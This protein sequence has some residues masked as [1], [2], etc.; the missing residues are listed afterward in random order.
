GL[1]IERPPRKRT[2]GG[3]GRGLA[4]AGDGRAQLG[5]DAGGKPHQFVAIKPSGERVGQRTIDPIK[6]AKVAAL[7]K[8]E[9]SI[10]KA[11]LLAQIERQAPAAAVLVHELR[12]R[13]A[14][15]GQ[16]PATD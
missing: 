13:L 7:G 2:Q 14:A 3:P 10:A 12:R 6:G 11:W 16:Q 9:G 4:A 15:G 8:A 5:I 1:N